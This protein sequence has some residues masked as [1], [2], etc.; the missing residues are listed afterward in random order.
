M[1][2]AY[3]YFL[4][5]IPIV[6]YFFLR[7]RKKSSLKFSNVNL[8][9]GKDKNTYKH[10]IGRYLIL[11]GSISLILALSRPQIPMGMNPLTEQGIDIAMLLDVSGSM[12]SVDF[13]PNRLEVAKDTI[14]DFINQRVEDRIALVIF[15]GNAYTRVPL[16][17][18]HEMV[19]SSINDVNVSSVKEKGTAIGMAISVGMNRLKKSDSASKIMILVTDGDNNA[20]AIDP[21][22]ASQLASDLGIKIYTIGVGTDVTLLPVDYFGVTKLQQVEGGLD[23]ELLENIAEKTG[24]AYYR[25]KDPEA[26]SE[27]FKS[28]N[29]LEKTDFQYDR[30]R[31]YTELAYFLM[32]IG[33][34]LLTIGLFLDRYYY[35]QIP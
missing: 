4:P 6:I 9:K 34:L 10:K 31:E 33:L 25:A 17:L 18:D 8:L 16:T 35:I 26:L 5:L 32:K 27:I 2:I 22:T 24:G 12:E 20:G 30:F 19:I 3:W 21:I 1:R 28:I 7:K 13:K 14:N 15:G 23:E 29:Q 11:L